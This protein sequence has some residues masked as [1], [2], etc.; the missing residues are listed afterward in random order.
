MNNRIRYTLDEIQRNVFY[1]MPKFLF[2]GEFENLSNDARVLYSLLRDRHDLSIRNKWVNESG[3]VYLIFSRENMCDMLKLSKKTVIK[4]MNDLKK[5]NLIEE[6]RL[7]QGKANHI[8]LLAVNS[9]L[10][11]ENNTETLKNIEKCNFSTSKSGEEISEVEILHFK[12]WNNYTSKGEEFPPQ[13][14]ENFHPNDTE[15][16]ELE[17]KDTDSKSKSTSDPLPLELSTGTKPDKTMTNDMDGHA[18]SGYL[19]NEKRLPVNAPPSKAS[20]SHESQYS[21]NTKIQKSVD[22]YTIYSQIIQDNIGYSDYLTYRPND[23]EEVDELV[24]CMLDVICTEGDTVK[25]NGEQKS[26][27]MVKSQ[28]LKIT[29]QDIDHI[30]DKFK[31]QRHKITHVHAYLKTMLFTCRQEN[32]HY[33]TN[34]VRADGMVW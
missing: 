13:K 25:I 9:S 32:G 4:A 8:Y 34:A 6:K 7:G 21:L 31:E 18:H 14:V 22:K 20:S 27:E 2:E 12:R 26:R 10:T 5:F 30:L 11:H 29:S 16:K 24:S 15:L 17:L 23:I 1:Q 33:Y 19:E 3:E 28:Y